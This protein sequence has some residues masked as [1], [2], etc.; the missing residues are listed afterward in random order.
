MYSK[1]KGEMDIF[2]NMSKRY[3][4]RERKIPI[5]FVT[6]HERDVSVAKAMLN[7]KERSGKPEIRFVTPIARDIE[8]A[9]SEKKK[10]KKQPAIFR[11]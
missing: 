4:A 10:S 5:K 8:L 6:S 11:S 7:V 9:K 3:I 2:K 1:S